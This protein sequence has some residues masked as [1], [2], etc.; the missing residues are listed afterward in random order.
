MA[1]R[2]SNHALNTSPQTREQRG[3]HR[4]SRRRIPAVLALAGLLGGG[5]LTVSA[6]GA[7][8]AAVPA[9]T[10]TVAPGTEIADAVNAQP[11][12]AVICLAAGRHILNRT[13]APKAQQELRGL[14]GSIVDGA[15][16]LKSW[17]AYQ[18]TGQPARW[19]SRG[20]LPAAYT[21]PGQCETAGSTSCNFAEDLF[22][23]GAR[24]RRVN[25]L[26]A[27]VPG[28]F[29]AD[30]ASNTLTIANTP[31]SHS[32]RMAK[33]QTAI[34]STQAGVKLTGLTVQHFANRSQRGAV[35]VSGSDW[36]VTGNTV[37]DNHGVGILTDQAVRPQILNNTVI[38]NGQ[39]G[40]TLYR[41]SSA[42]VTGNTVTGNNTAGYWIADWE[43]GGIKTTYSSALIQRNTVSGNLGV[44]VWAD[45][46]S[47]GITVDANT[48][49]GNYAD[50][51]RYEISRRGVITNNTVTDNAK[52]MGRGGGTGLWSGAGID[53]NTSSDVT[54]TGN[55]LR[56]NLNGISL[57]ARNRG[58]SSWGTY[59]LSKVTVSGNTVDMG[60]G[61]P[62]TAT[63]GVVTTK[64]RILTASSA[65][66]VFSRNSY[67]LTTSAQKGFNSINALV[68]YPG[69][70]SA[71][72]DST[73]S[74]A[75]L[76]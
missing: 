43:S 21:G 41:T 44:G 71:G 63:T 12:G 2:S 28:T 76:R 50:G 55:V 47:D 4:A 74:V 22:Y 25:S 48:I 18:V 33:L 61:S 64:D 9:C 10:V 26:A 45:V 42:T 17:T 14:P 24:L 31:V 40:V 15:K 36:K 57:Q 39:L 30:Y 51:I 19:Q 73:A 60:T 62:A 66:I 38:R 1:N 54:I 65:G 11:Q 8:E 72:F 6:P 27:V 7:A 75:Y 67:T 29:F 53:V 68:T 58:T 37:S 69:W 32:I 3:K 70:K 49:T 56:S 52:R 59:L 35:V 46:Q 34:S 5:L 16:P 20:N 23:D 13:V